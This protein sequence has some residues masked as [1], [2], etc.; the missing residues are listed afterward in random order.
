MPSPV[1]GPSRPASTPVAAS[2][3]VWCSVEASACL[4]D[5]TNRLHKHDTERRVEEGQI[6]A[7]NYGRRASEEVPKLRMLFG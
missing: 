1:V 4:I 5:E 2:A 7:M 6:D 3:V